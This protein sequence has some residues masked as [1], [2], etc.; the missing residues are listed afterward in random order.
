MQSSSDTAPSD[1]P[2]SVEVPAV[3]KPTV[4][5]T[6]SA[7]S[8]PTIENIHVGRESEACRLTSVDFVTTFPDSSIWSDKLSSRCESN[9]FPDDIRQVVEVGSS[10]AKTL[11][12]SFTTDRSPH[13]VIPST[14][15]SGL[16]SASELNTD[17]RTWAIQCSVQPNPSFLPR[18]IEAGK[19]LRQMSIAYATWTWKAVP[20]E[21]LHEGRKKQLA[22][23]VKMR[24]S[25]KVSLYFPL[26]LLQDLSRDPT[27]YGQ[28]RSMI[29]G[30]V[31]FGLHSQCLNHR[32]RRP[33]FDERTFGSIRDALLARMITEAVK[34]TSHW[35]DSK[36]YDMGKE[37]LMQR[38]GGCG[39][40]GSQEESNGPDGCPCRD[41]MER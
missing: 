13:C 23:G 4:S 28:F 20:T 25:L 24:R 10:G 7:A 40:G 5:L 11:R 14:K 36:G 31:L 30:E 3:V 6:N 41:H 15:P 17:P 19:V 39:G 22:E 38:C 34:P 12:S 35:I 16:K 37:R 27:R 2:I 21:L 18:R 1:T 32:T 26:R 8:C 29:L 33:W 9:S